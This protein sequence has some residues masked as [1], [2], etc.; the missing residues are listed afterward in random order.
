MTLSIKQ[1]SEIMRDIDTCLL[2]TV[3]SSGAIAT[4]PMSNNRSVEWDGTAWFFTRDDSGM[5]ADLSANPT[6]LLAYQG[7]KGFWAGVQG[8]ASVHTDRERL[9]EHWDP[10]VER[11]FS[12]GVDTEGIVLLEIRAKRVSYWTYEH[13]DGHLDV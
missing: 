3:T 12:D 4:R 10:D 11:W 9:V 8:E 2:C 13:G 7:E 1:L 6:A 5:V